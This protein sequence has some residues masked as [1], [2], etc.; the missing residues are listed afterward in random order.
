MVSLVVIQSYAQSENNQP[1]IHGAFRAVG[2]M[3]LQEGTH[4]FQ[5][6]N[7]RVIIAGRVHPKADYYF[8]T[9]LCDVG[10]MRILDAFGR[11]SVGGKLKIKVGQFVV[12]FR[13]PQRFI[14]ANRSF[15]AKKMMTYRAV[16]AQLSYSFKN[17]PIKVE[18]SI[19][20]PSTIGR[21]E[22][23]NHSTAFSGRM[24]YSDNFWQFSTGIASTKPYSI[25]ANLVDGSFAWND[26]KH[27][28][29]FGEYMYETY[30]SNAGKPVH[31]W[32]GFVDWHQNIKLGSF[33]RF[34]IQ[35]REE[36]IT[37]HLTLDESTTETD[38][39]RVTIGS[40]FSYISQDIQ[41]DIRL[42]YENNHS[43]HT[44]NTIIGS[45]NQMITEL[46]ILF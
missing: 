16:G 29:V 6:R 22:E 15:I 28:K 8:H 19:T 30:S 39:H 7:A 11:I 2:E 37:E 45:K 24:I 44:Q 3:D 27:W 18:T 9:D 25:R 17:I 31:T 12:P 36:G 1:G 35:V 21:Q 5:V 14:F 23:W 42:N 41:F 38:R 46:V 43:H 13:N 4:R 20:N 10:T 26:K 34:S 32:L 33:N 40:T